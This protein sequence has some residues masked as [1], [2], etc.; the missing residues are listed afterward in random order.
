MLIRSN[1]TGGHSLPF[2]SSTSFIRKVVVSFKNFS[3][4]LLLVPY[5]I[6]IQTLLLLHIPTNQNAC[7]YICIYYIH[8][9]NIGVIY[10][11]LKKNSGSIIF[12]IWVV[13]IYV[14]SIIRIEL[15]K[16]KPEPHP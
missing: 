7:H 12:Y 4:Q 2:F 11:K 16:K 10:V 9:A 5:P 1:Q 14:S 13:S 15:L 6:P 3:Q 8:L